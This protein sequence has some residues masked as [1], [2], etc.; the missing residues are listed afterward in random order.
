MT[1][2]MGLVLAAFLLCLLII[3]RVTLTLTRRK[4]S[5]YQDPVMLFSG[6]WLIQSVA[7]TLPVFENRE[8]LEGRHILY[9]LACHVAFFV[10]VLLVPREKLNPDKAGDDTALISFPMLAAIGLA[11][12]I[13]N[14][15]VAY[16]GLHIS[17]V[18]L[19]DR[20]TAEGLELTRRE[21]FSMSA[22][23]LG[24]LLSLEFLAS[25]TT[26][27][28]CMMTAGVAQRLT[29]KR[30]QVRALVLATVVS[31]LFV[32]FNTLIVHGGRLYLV[33]LLVGAG[34]GALIDPKRS[35][36]RAVDRSLGRAK[37]GV[38][39]LLLAGVIGSIWFFSTTFV[40]GRLGE[41]TPPLVSLYQYHRAEP[42]P[43]V[44][45]LIGDN[46]TLQYALLSFS[47]ITVPLTTLV[48]YYD[49][50]NGQ[51]PGPY[52]G[53]YNFSKP[54]TFV[55][56]RLGK[57]RDQMTVGDIRD[58]ATRYLR[59]MGYGD[60]VWPTM[61]RDLA[62]DVSWAGVPIVML[63]LGWGAELIMRGARRDGN[64]IMKV[65]GL[66]TSVLLVFSIA[67]SL[68]ILDAFQKA[69]WFCFALLIYRRFFH[70]KRAKADKAG[71]GTSV[72]P[73]PV[74]PSALHHEP[75]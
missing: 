22:G 29:L 16:D 31:V 37:G 15:A 27:F 46:Q 30:W 64:F 61:L 12:L 14:F 28:V 35:L 69:F 50:P 19:L 7:F 60:N 63:V 18:G 71:D 49:M 10:G 59:V 72:A 25:A 20:F 9:I 56:R 2:S 70:G 11:G 67:H 55:M 36:L 51:F 8:A 4:I 24:P 1:N 48:Y 47:Y 26:I 74:H 42:T 23:N 32:A 5:W 34:L 41:E 33:L 65:L 73:K 44:A 38:Y 58:E 21:R 17:S 6:A 62:L 13:G 53:Q 39:T 3:R 45:D 52:W 68:L 40:K 66:L 57:V 54:A 75:H 43:A